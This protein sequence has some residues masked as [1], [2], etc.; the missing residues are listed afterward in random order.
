MAPKIAVFL[1]GYDKLLNELELQDF[2]TTYCTVGWKGISKNSKCQHSDPYQV[3]FGFIS[4]MKM[5]VTKIWYL[6]IQKYHVLKIY[7]TLFQGL[8]KKGKLKIIFQVHSTPRP[9][10]I[11]KFLEK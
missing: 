2:D 1:N 3:I 11:I 5:G 7:Y 9:L 4:D 10:S 8:P 6:I